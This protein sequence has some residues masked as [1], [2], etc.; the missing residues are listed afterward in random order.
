[1]NAPSLRDALMRN[2][3]WGVGIGRP[4]RGTQ[5]NLLLRRA[6]CEKPQIHGA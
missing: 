2:A 3:F 6:A 4:W 1:M 5:E